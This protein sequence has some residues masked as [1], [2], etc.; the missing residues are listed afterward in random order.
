MKDI[1]FVDVE[2][3]KDIVSDE[4]VYYT[5]FD[6][7]SIETISDPKLKELVIEASTAMNKLKAYIGEE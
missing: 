4:G 7:V 6:Y 2:K 3:F 5:T 1:K